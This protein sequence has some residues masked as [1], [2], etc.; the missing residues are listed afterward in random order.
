MSTTVEVSVLELAS[1]MLGSRQLLRMRQ[2]IAL[3]SLF[4]FSYDR[5][6]SQPA[7]GTIHPLGR[8]A[9]YPSQEMNFQVHEQ[10][11]KRY[12]ARNDKTIV[13]L[14]LGIFIPLPKTATG[15]S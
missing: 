15:Q 8:P 1:A 13:Q 5:M 11:N 4:R 3:S 10:H 14:N 6:I 12:T 2:Q 7:V 9:T